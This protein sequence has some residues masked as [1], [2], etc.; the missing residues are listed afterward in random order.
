[1]ATIPLTVQERLDAANLAY[2]Q[3]VT[4]TMP[5]VVVDQSGQRV[6]YT[7]TI[8][9]E[10]KGNLVFNAATIWWS[11]GLSE[12]PGFLKP[13]AHG[14]SPRGVDARVQRMTKN[15]FDRFLA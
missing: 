15:L 8:H 4:G 7:A 9:P 5:R 3:L 14:G 13:S 2:H 12:P 10:A 1:M 6:E 11:L